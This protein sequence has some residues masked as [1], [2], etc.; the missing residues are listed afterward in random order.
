MDYAFF[1]TEVKLTYKT[2]TINVC[3][4]NMKQQIRLNELNY[5][6]ALIILFLHL[7][8]SGKSSAADVNAW[9]CLGGGVFMLTLRRDAWQA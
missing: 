9:L 6:P 2:N 8:K 3:G 4:L 7:D 1:L 5:F